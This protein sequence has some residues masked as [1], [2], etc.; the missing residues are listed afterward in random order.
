MRAQ[1]G[2]ALGLIGLAAA[3][4]LS[5]CG[6]GGGGG[7]SEGPTNRAPFAQAGNDLTVKRNASVTLD[8]SG[9]SDP[10]GDALAYRWT[11]TA[12]TPVTLSSNTAGRPSFTAPGQSGTLSFSLVASDGKTES[13]ADSVTVTVQNK[14]PTAIS[15]GSMSAGPGSMATLDATG[16]FDPD[17]DPLTYAW[18]QLSG[19]AVTISTVGPGLGQFQVPSVPVVLVFALTVSDGEATS[20]TI[21][22]TVNVIIVTG[23][24]QAPVVNAGPD[25]DAPRRAPVTLFGTAFDPNFDSP[26]TYSWEQISGPAV[27]LSG[28]DT[29]YLTFTAPDTPARLKFAFRASDGS[30]TSDPAEIEVNVRNFAPEVFS[31]VITPNAPRTLDTLSFDAQVHDADNDAVTTTY[32][33]SRNGTVVGSQTTS[34]FPASLTTKNDV[35]TAHVTVDDGFSQTTVDASTTILDSP[36]VL[37]TT[38]PPPTELDYGDTANFSFTATDADG[39]AIPGFEVAF[40]PAGFAV[41]SQGVATWTAVGPLFES[42]TDFVWGVRVTGD[43]SSLL[44]GSIKVTDAARLDP[45]RRTGVRIPVQHNGLTIADLDGDGDNEM[46][47]GASTALYVLSKSGSGY[48][49]S[50]VYPF[51][52]GTS[53]YSNVISAVAAQ[54]IDGDGAQ[55][56]FYSKGALLLRLD[57]VTRREVA[58]TSRRC[59]DIELG[60]LDRNGSVELVC[61]AAASDY[62]FETDVRIVV[63]DPR[64]L[65]EIWSSP[66]L[67]LG[68]TLA[69]GNVDADAALEI[70]TAGGFVF[71]GQSR[72][73]QWSYSQAFGT[74][75]DTGDVDGDGVEEI[76]GMGDWSSVRAFS[77]VAKSPLWEYVPTWTDLDA[78][79]VADANGDGRVEVIVGN[80]QWGNVMGIGYNSATHQGELLW[81]IN[82]QEHGVTSIAVGDVDGSAGNEVVWGTGATSSGRDDFVVAGFT[83]SISVKWQASVEPE[84]DGPF[85]GGALA[86]IGGG[87][88]RLMFIA[89]MTNSGYAGMRA[90]GLHPTTGE[91]ELS[92]EI[93][94]NFARAGAMDVADY[95]NDGVDELFLSTAAYYDGYFAAYDFAADTL[96]WQSPQ[97]QSESGIAVRHADVNDDGHADFI[98]LSSA[99]YV[100]IYDVHNQSLIWKSTQLGGAVALAV[101]DLDDDGKSEIVVATMNRLIVYGKAALGSNYLERASIAFP[102]AMDLVVA[103]LDGDHAAEIYVL[104]QNFS[105]NANLVVLDAQLQTLR[106]VPLN[107]TATALYVEESAFARKNLLLAVGGTVASNFA[108][109]IWAIDPVQGVDVWRSPGI[110]GS[111]QRNSLYFVDVD[112]DGDREIS[113]ATTDGLYH[114]R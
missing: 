102:S 109:E 91:L 99:G 45:I 88:S 75:V 66:Q 5:A 4:C 84:I 42:A 38:A 24:N 73:N 1:Q 72:Q 95:D 110:A 113:F 25:F 83:P 47:V 100:T 54:D 101:A 87:A 76:I 77:A 63:L 93:G 50:W 92:A 71:D 44:S 53:D 36:A 17:G 10:D 27:T 39:D 30:L 94:T 37:A 49:Q 43:Q 81:E 70:V 32:Q 40:G 29:P 74:A 46:L 69:L 86:R 18:T 2:P 79:T 23:P 82:S 8:G 90:I 111:V 85:M 89:P 64:T 103:D 96:E 107:V 6:G 98:G 61:L 22:I 3:L 28:A 52:V 78:L 68:G 16:S 34:T 67:P 57:G 19:P 26:L 97:T 12:G 106:T 11:Q 21:N 35:I 48:Q 108:P 14:A 55:E 80:G 33:W 112:G 62:F 31:A 59:R 60:D 65:Q 41:S 105:T 13:P 104:S 114:T 15:Q 56:I 7:G 58:R 9:S 20:V 51:E